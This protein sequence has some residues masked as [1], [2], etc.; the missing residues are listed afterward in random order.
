MHADINTLYTLPQASLLLFQ[1]SKETV[2][3]PRKNPEQG[4]IERS[5]FPE[6]IFKMKL[7]IVKD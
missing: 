7:L 5:V 1:L 6:N 2:A 4:G 3:G